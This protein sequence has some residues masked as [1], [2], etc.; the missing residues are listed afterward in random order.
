[1]SISKLEKTTTVLH[2]IVKKSRVK[3]DFYTR[4]A[5]Q[6]KNRLQKNSPHEVS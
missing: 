6:K 4:K 3:D 2:K 5:Q 1:M